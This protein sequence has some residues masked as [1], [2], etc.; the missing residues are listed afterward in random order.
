MKRSF[1]AAT[2]FAGAAALGVAAMAAA[3]APAAHASTPAR[4][5]TCGANTPSGSGQ[6]LHLYYKV[7]SHNTAGCVEAYGTGEYAPLA[8]TRFQY[9]CGGT[10]SGYLF[11]SGQERHFTD[12]YTYHKLYNALVSGIYISQVHPTGLNYCYK[13]ASDISPSA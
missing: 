9:Y 4:A 3:P 8:P 5:F 11:I 7:K 1:R 13:Y 6:F 2:V 10:Y 12:G